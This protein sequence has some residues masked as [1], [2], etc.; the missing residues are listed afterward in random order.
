MDKYGL[1]GSQKQISW[2]EAIID[3]KVADLDLSDLELPVCAGW[4]IDRRKDSPEQIIEAIAN[5]DLKRK[6]DPEAVRVI[7]LRA[8][9]YHEVRNEGRVFTWIYRLTYQSETG[10]EVDDFVKINSNDAG[11]VSDGME[12]IS[13]KVYAIKKAISGACM[14]AREVGEGPIK[15]ALKV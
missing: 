12:I 10:H 5:G 7:D 1:I 9:P 14:R 2:A 4:W 11:V 13:A 6:V 3:E 15:D 8:V